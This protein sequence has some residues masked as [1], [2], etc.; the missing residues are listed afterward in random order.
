M[1]RTLLK[2]QELEQALLQLEH[3]QL[4]DKKIERNF[5]FKS[6][7]DAFGFMTKV[8]LEAEKIDHHPDWSNSYNKV[9]IDLTTHSSG[10]I[11]QLDIDLALHINK[12]YQ[13]NT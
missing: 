6:F 8:A 12:L 5:K 4:A 9:S 3:W 13:V 10:G 2:P 11:T 1:N 7:S